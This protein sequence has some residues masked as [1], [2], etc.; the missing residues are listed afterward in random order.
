MQP[1]YEGKSY[2]ELE[3]LYH[4]LSARLEEATPRGTLYWELKEEIEQVEMALNEL[5]EEGL[6]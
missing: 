6:D 4:D 5:M 1:E 2:R 3:E